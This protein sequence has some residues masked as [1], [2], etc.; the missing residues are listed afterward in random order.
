M[1]ITFVNERVAIYAANE[2]IQKLPSSDIHD[3]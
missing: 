2:K 3:N 1:A